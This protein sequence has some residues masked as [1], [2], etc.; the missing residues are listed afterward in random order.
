MNRFVQSREGPDANFW[1]MVTEDVLEP[2]G[3]R[4]LPISRTF[5]VSEADSIPIMGWGS[6]PDGV[7]FA[8]LLMN[9]LVPLIDHFTIP[10]A[11]GHAR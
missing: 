1:Q 2:I 3:V 9:M 4:Q 8:V 7:A 10:R 5:E 11:Y 6:Y